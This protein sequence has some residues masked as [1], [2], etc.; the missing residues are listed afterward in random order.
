MTKIEDIKT[1]LRLFEDAA[2]KQAEATENGNYKLGNKCY[3]QIVNAI[4]FLKEH[5]AID[6]LLN[7]LDNS[8]VSVRMWAASSLLPKYEK[9]SIRV[10]EIIAAGSGIHSLTAETTL[11]EWK[12]GNLK[13]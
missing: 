12:E 3:D 8:S 10:L 9:E 11:T 7:F 5:D 13:F 6:S 2:A 1:A 4:A